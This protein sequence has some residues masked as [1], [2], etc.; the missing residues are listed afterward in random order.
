MWVVCLGY[1]LLVGCVYFVVVSVF[2]FDLG[3]FVFLWWWLM[4]GVLELRFGFFCDGVWWRYFWLVELC[5]LLLLLWKFMSCCFCGSYE[6]VLFC[7]YG[8]WNRKEEEREGLGGRKNLG[9]RVLVIFFIFFSFLFRFVVSKVGILVL[10]W[11]CFFFGLK[12]FFFCYVWI[13]YLFKYII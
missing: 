10:D 12:Y 2:W 9:F 6:W 1:V 5:L 4:L 8:N 7:G 3:W 13:Y 11:V